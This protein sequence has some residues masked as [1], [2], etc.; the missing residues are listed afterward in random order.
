MNDTLEHFGIKGMKWGQRK[1][2]IKAAKKAKKA[3]KKVEN[4]SRKTTSEWSNKY[5]QRSKMSDE[6]LQRAINR[7][8][9]EN[10][11]AKQV[12][13]SVKHVPK[14]PTKRL[15]S[16][17]IKTVNDI[18]GAVRGVNKFTGDVSG[19]GKN[20]VSAYRSGVTTLNLD[21]LDVRTG[22]LRR[23]R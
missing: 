3:R 19:I 2:K 1:A 5:H 21:N 22:Q 18:S 13:S 15:A 12:S 6:E 10:E 16:N 9:L 17:A 8:R 14:T 11:L 7:L 20:T 23:S 4:L